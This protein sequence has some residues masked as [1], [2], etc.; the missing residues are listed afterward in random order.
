MGS[1]LDRITTDMKAAMKSG[2]KARLEVLR[3]LISDLKKKAIDTQQDALKDE[4]EVAI[5][6]KAVKTRADS[7]AQATAAGR[8]EIA[9]R[10]QAEIE[11]VQSYLPQQMSADQVL[12]KVRALATEIGYGGGKD[13]GRFMKE[14]MARYKG[15][16]AGKLVQD[17]LRSLG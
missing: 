8:A 17:A 6:Q 10:E 13:T 15:E 7:V 12:A 1:H 16:A 11:V 3:M 14:W 4:D 2:D 5:L 9:S